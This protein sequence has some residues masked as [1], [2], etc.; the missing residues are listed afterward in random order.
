MRAHLHSVVFTPEP[1]SVTVKPTE[2]LVLR[3]AGGK[4]RLPI[5]GATVS[6][7]QWAVT[8]AAQ[9]PRRS[10]AVAEK[11]Y[12]PSGRFPHWA[13]GTHCTGTPSLTAA[14]P[15]TMHALQYG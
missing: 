11:L 13:G 10:V 12:R 3:V 1:E 4:A 14:L 6:T 15:A 8:G 9:F 7:S 5:S 2:M